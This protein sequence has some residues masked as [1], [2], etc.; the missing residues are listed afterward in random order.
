MYMYILTER[1]IGKSKG[2]GEFREKVVFKK[3]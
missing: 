1:I 2:Y 3:W